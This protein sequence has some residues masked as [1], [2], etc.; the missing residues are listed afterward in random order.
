[1]SSLLSGSLSPTPAH[2]LAFLFCVTLCHI[3]TRSL[4]GEAVQTLSPLGMPGSVVGVWGLSVQRSGLCLYQHLENELING[5][6]Q[7]TVQLKTVIN[8]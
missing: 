7:F 4:S 3:A 8:A 6:K 2:P 1:M 5:L